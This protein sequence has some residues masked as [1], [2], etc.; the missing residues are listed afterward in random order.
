M[1]RNSDPLPAMSTSNIVVRSNQIE[2]VSDEP[3]AAFGWEGLVENVL[4]EQNTVQAQGA[5]FGITAYGH[6]DATQSGEIRGVE[7]IGNNIEGSRNGAIGVMGGAE[8]VDIVNNQVEGTEEDGI[9][10][11]PGGDGLPAISNITVSGISSINSDTK[12]PERSAD[13]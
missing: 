10:L 7:I 4:I 6:T 13:R 12:N 8:N 5:S 9:F 1:I 3:I 11:D 2:S